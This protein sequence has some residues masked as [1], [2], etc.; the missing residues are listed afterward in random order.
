[1]AQMMKR[2]CLLGVQARCACGCASPGALCARQH[3]LFLLAKL[4][5]DA[6]LSACKQHEQLAKMSLAGI[7]AVCRTALLLPR[8]LLKL[9]AMQGPA[10]WMGLQGEAWLAFSQLAGRAG[11]QA[12]T[13]LLPAATFAL[14]VLQDDA[15]HA[16]YLVLLAAGLLRRVVMPAAG[17]WRQVICCLPAQTCQS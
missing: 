7:Q 13:L 1:M 16:G 11:T 10:A 5:N 6:K 3:L 15:L 9:H 14:G 8:R 2:S 4:S 17:T 12:C